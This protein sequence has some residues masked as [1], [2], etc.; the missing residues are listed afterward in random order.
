MPSD[1]PG[2][3]GPCRLAAVELA[4]AEVVAWDAV[5]ALPLLTCFR[6]GKGKV[7]V[8]TAWAYPGHE[9]LQRFA[10]AWIG[11][12]AREHRGKWFADDPSGEVFWSVRRF[13]DPRCGQ[14][15]MLNT[16]WTQPGNRKKIAV[17]AGGLI[18]DY[19]VVERVPAMLTV[20]GSSILETAP[21]NYLEYRGVHGNAAEFSLH[22]CGKASV[23][24]R[25]A[26]GTREINL[27]TAPGGALFTVDME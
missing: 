2:E 5:T 14:L 24:I 6:C 11:K 15:F 25:S 13:D 10:A 22:A 9:A 20:A 12:L 16:D 21:E 7:Y 3:D 17:H 27:Q 18:F 19:E 8:I 4:G 26:A 1:F 23:T